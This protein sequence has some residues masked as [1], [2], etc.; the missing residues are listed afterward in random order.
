LV[1]IKGERSMKYEYK[2]VSAKIE[3]SGV[4][5]AKQIPE[6]E[7]MLNHYAKYGWRLKEMIMPQ[8]SLGTASEIVLVLEREAQESKQEE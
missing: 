6:L 3:G 5:S 2:C 7:K 8:V 1:V 4:F